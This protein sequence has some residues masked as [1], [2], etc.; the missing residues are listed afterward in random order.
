MRITGGRLRSRRIAVPRGDLEI[1]PAMDRMRESFF[2]ILGAA[3][4][5]ASFLD[6]F[7]GSGIVGIEAWSRGAEKVVLVEKDASKRWALTQNAELTEGGA[8]V[9]IIPAESFIR[10]SRGGPFDFV[11]LDPPFPYRFRLQLLT[12]LSDSSLLAPGARVM[13]HHP[14]EEDLPEKAGALVRD[15]RRRYGRSV[16]SFY[17]RE[18]SLEPAQPPKPVQSPK[19]S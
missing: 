1:R 13:I 16:L 19:P 12:R 6:L 4:E 2:S 11:F 17:R 8:A 3:L 14:R 15:D 10:D 5:G 18:E 9:R 7:S